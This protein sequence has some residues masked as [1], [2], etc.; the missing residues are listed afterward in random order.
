MYIEDAR[1]SFFW[2]LQ[3]SFGTQNAPNF[4][5]LFDYTN[6]RNKYKQA[7]ISLFHILH[8]SSPPYIYI[9]DKNQYVWTSC[10]M[11]YH[12]RMLDGLRFLWNIFLNFPLEWLCRKGI[13]LTLDKE[14]KHNNSESEMSRSYFINFIVLITVV[15]FWHET[16]SISKYHYHRYFIDLFAFET[17]TYIGTLFQL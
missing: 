3:I 8:N 14:R 1:S 17:S 4:F 5:T 9:Y 13:T 12:S 6:M 16:N 15:F 7:I 2:K 10:E 11:L